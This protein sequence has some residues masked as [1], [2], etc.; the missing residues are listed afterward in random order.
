MRRCAAVLAMLRAAAIVPRTRWHPQA[1]RHLAR[2]TKLLGATPDVAAARSRDDPLLNF[3]FTYYGSDLGAAA[4]LGRWCPPVGVAIEASQDDR[5]RLW[6]GIESSGAYDPRKL[7]KKRLAALERGRA[8]LAATRKR[9]PIWHCYGLHEWAMLYRPD[10]APQPHKHQS[11]PLRVDQATINRV[12]EADEIKCTHFDAF[13]FFAPEA[14]EKNR[15]AL[16]RQTQLDHEQPACVH[17]N[18]DLLRYA[19]RL[20]PFVD[21]ALIGDAL[22]VALQ[23]RDLDIRASPYLLAGAAPVEVETTAGRKEYV[24]RQAAV[25][26]AAAPVRD[27]LL[28]AY[29]DFFLAHALVPDARA[30]TRLVV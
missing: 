8:A 13:R 15:H 6:R 21:A 7:P 2:V 5:E 17:A 24:R 14:T 19:L 4:N 12:V 1:E 25:H 10:G 3:V 28:A 9:P 27:R 18:M 23:A 26:D 11:L 22:D 29:D 30:E 20:T 16:T